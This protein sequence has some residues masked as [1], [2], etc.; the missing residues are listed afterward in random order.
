MRT[1]KRGPVTKNSRQVSAGG[2]EGRLVASGAANGTK[3]RWMP[4]Q[5]RTPSPYGAH[6]AW[7]LMTLVPTG[8]DAIILRLPLLQRHHRRPANPATRA[9]N[10]EEEEETNGCDEPS[11]A[12][13]QLLT[14]YQWF[15]VLV[16]ACLAEYPWSLLLTRTLWASCPLLLCRWPGSRSCVAL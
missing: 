15:P 14:T 12:L 13:M 4:D 5:C 6:D 10:A 3:Y 9:A 16:S 11:N 8:P 2:H 7:F 1:E